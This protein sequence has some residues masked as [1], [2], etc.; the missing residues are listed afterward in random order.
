MNDRL[1]KNVSTRV[2]VYSLLAVFAIYAIFFGP[3]AVQSRNMKRASSI[4][5]QIKA[6]LRNDAAY[7]DL[8]ILYSTGNLG[9]DIRIKG[10]VPTEAQLR[11][12]K[13]LINTEFQD[14]VINVMLL[15]GVRPE[16]TTDNM[17]VD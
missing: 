5:K 9:R 1:K 11:L 14:D 3:A 2:V 6:S 16:D 8:Q 12:L 17:V 10:Y 7:S 4:G 13:E 15:V